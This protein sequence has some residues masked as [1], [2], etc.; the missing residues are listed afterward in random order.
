MIKCRPLRLQLNDIGTVLGGHVHFGTGWESWVRVTES[1]I[2][3]DLLWGLHED[4]EEVTY[5]DT[6]SCQIRYSSTPTPSVR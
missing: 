4:P 1:R 6:Y 3:A 2:F 5:W